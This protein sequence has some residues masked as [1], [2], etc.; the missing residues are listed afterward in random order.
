VSA[1]ER[2]FPSHRRE[3]G[4]AECLELLREVLRPPRRG[5]RCA[6]TWTRPT[7]RAVAILPGANPDW[8][9]PVA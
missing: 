9:S 1:P 6:S 7:H 3:M 2:W 4:T 5:R 8:S